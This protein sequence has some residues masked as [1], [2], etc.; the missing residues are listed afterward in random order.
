MKNAAPQ[1]DSGRLQDAFERT[2]SGEDLTPEAV[3]Q[4]LEETAVDE[5]SA[6]TVERYLEKTNNETRGAFRTKTATH[7]AEFTEADELPED[8]LESGVHDRF[9]LIEEIGKGAAGRIYAMRDNSLNRTIAVKFL[10]KTRE[11]K[12]GV[13][14]QFITEARV[15]AMLEH[16]N[17]M[18]VYDIGAT[19]KNEIFFTMRQVTGCSIGDAIRKANTGEEVPE[20]FRTCDGRVRIFLKVCDALAYAHHQGFVHQDIKPDNIMLGEFGEVLLLDWGSALSLTK[21]GPGGRNLYGTP[22]YMSPE[23]ARRERA[24]ERSDVYCVGASFFH[25]LFLRHPTW[26]EDPDEF[27]EKKRAGVIDPITDAERRRVPAALSAIVLKAMDHDPSK[28]Y[29]SIHELADDLKRYQA[30]RAVTAHRE[31]LVESFLRWYRNNRRLFWAVSVSLVVIGG[32]GGI[33]FREKLKELITWRRFYTDNFAYPSTEALGA[34]WKGYLSYN[35]RDIAHQPFSDTGGWRIENGALHGYN[36]FGMH[37]ITFNRDVPGDIRVEWR[38]TPLIQPLN[39]NCYIAG[40]TRRDGY[41]FHIGGFD[42]PRTIRLTKGEHVQVLDN[43]TLDHG[44]TVGREYRFRMEKEGPHVR[45][46]KDGKKVIDYRDIDD[47]S[48]EGHQ[49]FG[50]EVNQ[51]NHIRIDDVEVYYHPLP[52]KVSPLAAADRFYQHG[53]YR[54]ALTQYREIVQLY[55]SYDIALEA[56]YKIGTCLQMMDSTGHALEVYTRFG[57]QHPKHE[58]APLALFERAGIIEAAGDTAT[59]ER[60]LME[61]GRRFPGHVILR[62]AIFEMTRE[63]RNEWIH[64]QDEWDERLARD[65]TYHLWLVD[66]SR[67]LQ[68]WGR[69][70]GVDLAGN[71]F[72]QDAGKTLF[73]NHKVGFGGL[74]SLFPAQRE[75]QAECLLS[76]GEL[77]R[78]LAEYPDRTVQCAEAL[79]RMGQHRRLVREYPQQRRYCALSLI[80]LGRYEEV[81]RRY[82]DRPK[83][84]ALALLGLGRFDEVF[85]KYPDATGDTA[86]ELGRYDEYIDAV[87]DGRIAFA[88]ALTH[89]GRP[90][91]ALRLLESGDP[92]NEIHYLLAIKDALT[93]LGRPEEFIQRY[94][95]S[96]AM[97]QPVADVYAVMGRSGDVLALMHDDPSIRARAFLR[98]GQYDSVLQQYGNDDNSWLP[99][100]WHT[101]RQRELLETYPDRRNLRAAVLLSLNKFKRIVEKYPDQREPAAK[102]LYRL[103]RYTDILDDYPDRR[104]MCY[105]ALYRMDKPEEALRRYPESRA[106]YA[107]YLLDQER[108]QDVVDSFPDQLFEYSRALLAL[109]RPHEAPLD[110]GAYRLKADPAFELIGHWALRAFG[111]G[112]RAQAYRLLEQRRTYLFNWHHHRFQR[113]FLAAVLRALDGDRGALERACASVKKLYRYHHNQRL[114]YEASYLAG[115][116]GETAFLAQPFKYFARERLVLLDAIL[117]DIDGD[118]ET[119]LHKYLALAGAPHCREPSLVRIDEIAGGT[120]D[121]S[122]VFESSVVQRFIRWRI[123]ELREQTRNVPRS[124]ADTLLEPLG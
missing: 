25:A 61:L 11:K 24:D 71:L 78:V 124:Y 38:V 122:V 98:R 60:I 72:L 113:F 115:D 63:L 82:P 91:S 77:E 95:R 2:R 110:T 121:I 87:R 21:S 26:A 18:P 4:E 48:G 46:Y 73:D 118:Q 44:I 41:T 15:T 34:N 100:M 1:K 42:N 37:N 39:L 99:A 13:K 83:E 86:R 84:R 74:V 53:Y 9:H 116:I 66:A 75:L 59:A 47:L 117:L 81:L 40:E 111:D 94:G 64:R 62:T 107:Q 51:G 123:A 67:R 85:E 90:D 54:E 6:H 10:Q 27:W 45:L 36:S 58:L 5:T 35:W 32:V 101:N 19:E 3:R 14:R 43:H 8:L 65:S 28:R 70:F 50:F 112:D 105:R 22:A 120:I 33:L 7:I 97:K 119:A 96:Y 56:Q 80:A 23:Q 12:R 93:E 68:R 31:T 108:Y 92:L 17:I 89:I 109:G 52:L 30:G 16:P 104:E 57:E 102:A 79:H 49:R 29:Q 69:Q 106:A 114:Y 55:G 20:E 103:R 76:L 88:R